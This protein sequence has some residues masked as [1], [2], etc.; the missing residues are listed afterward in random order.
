MLGT[1]VE[2]MFSGRSFASKNFSQLISSIPTKDNRLILFRI[3]GK[4]LLSKLCRYK[5][6]PKIKNDDL[7]HEDIFRGSGNDKVVGVLQGLHWVVMGMLTMNS[8]I[9]IVSFRK[10]Q[11]LIRG[12]H[13]FSKLRVK[14]RVHLDRHN[15]LANAHWERRERILPSAFGR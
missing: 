9:Y 8:N 13:Q 4:F 3:E 12:C 2:L 1:S 10:G 6:R 11:S 14:K 5:V 15:K 7:V